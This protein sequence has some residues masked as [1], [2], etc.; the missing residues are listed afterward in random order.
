MYRFHALSYRAKYEDR[1]KFM[2]MVAMI[3]ETHWSDDGEWII[4]NDGLVE[5]F[6][7]ILD[8]LMERRGGDE[9]ERVRCFRTEL[10]GDTKQTLRSVMK[11]V[12]PLA[13]L[14]HGDF[15]RNN[16]LF[17]YDNSGRPADALAFDMATVRYGSP[18]LDLSFFLYMNADRRTRDDHWDE[19][20]DAYCA[21]LS[22]AVSDVA[23]V[24]RVP[25]RERLD[26]EMRERAFYGLAHVSFFVRFM[27]EEHRSVDPAQFVDMTDDDMLKLLMTFGGDKATDMIADAVQHFIDML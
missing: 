27:T 18:A 22:A 23:D 25:D 13:V 2:N 11:P 12:E 6:S 16:M 17:L 4:R 20:L 8:R 19:L 24:V 14:C 21:A 3:E 10:L 9:D 7:V 26:V 1:E 5:L 15:N